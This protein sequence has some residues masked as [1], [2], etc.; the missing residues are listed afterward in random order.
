[1]KNLE[2]EKKSSG[3]YR[4]PEV[5]FNL[6]TGICKIEGE[7]FMDDSESFYSELINWILDFNS[8]FPE[9]KIVL[10]L[11]LSFFNTSTA[12]MIYELLSVLEDFNKKGYSVEANW[13]Y[14]SEDEE[15]AEDVADV[16]IDIDMKINLIPV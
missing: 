3:F 14:Y 15:I 2:I 9:K 8:F 1:M 4:S 7:S 13:R 5:D 10:N 16:C 11:E 12:K 6:T